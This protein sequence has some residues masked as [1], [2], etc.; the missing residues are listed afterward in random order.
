[1]INCSTN[2]MNQHRTDPRERLLHRFYEPLVLLWIL[3]PNQGKDEAEMPHE[4]RSHHFTVAWRRFLDGACF[5]CDAEKG[6]A[7]VCALAAEPTP[8]GSTFWF[9]ATKK[10]QAEHLEWILHEL[11]TLDNHASEPAKEA[12]TNRIAGHTVVFAKS[13]VF[14]YGQF[15]HAAIIQ[16]VHSTCLPRG[17]FGKQHFRY[18]IG[19]C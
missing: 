5:M 18:V 7:G 2:G 11:C 13:K 14:T 4:A 12:V 6:G 15:L 8:S 19:V 17:R 16:A 3:N 9:A 1:M 10:D